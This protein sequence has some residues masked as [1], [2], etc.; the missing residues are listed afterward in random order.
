V[1]PENEDGF[2]LARPEDDARFRI[3]RNGDNLMTQFQCDLCQFRNIMMR[4]P[5]VERVESDEWLQVCIRR[6]ILDSLWSREPSTVRGNLTECRRAVK[7]GE[8]FGF[9]N[10]YSSMGP[11]PIEDSWG[12]KE[13]CILLHRSLDTGKNDITIQFGTMRKLRSAFSNAFHASKY[14]TGLVTMAQDARKT[15]VTDSPTYG[16]WF[17]RFMLG[18]HKRMGEKVKQ[19]MGVSIGVMHCL[20]DIFEKDF[21]EAATDKDKLFVCLAAL[22]CIASFCGG[23]RGEEVPMADLGEF[24]KHAEKGEDPRLPHIV[25]PLIGRFK[26]ER[27]EKHHLLPLAAV[28]NSGLEPRKWSLR[29]IDCYSKLH[30]FN[31]PI[32]RNKRGKQGRISDWEGPILDKIKEVQDG[33]PKLIDPTVDVHDEYGLSRSFRRGSNTH[34]RNQNLRNV[35]DIVEDNNRWRKFDRAKGRMPGMGMSDYY[36]EIRQAMPRLILYSKHQ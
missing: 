7:I 22:Y 3:G 16:I 17:Q 27:G 23:L 8:M 14:S 15:V 1:S 25:L 33:N 24:I 34:L 11:F 35:Q 19:D 20:M 6:A 4:D 26:G 5:D 18:C 9:K 10:N 30:V 36:T 13:A 12:L 2:Q 21:V 29:V 28:T 31:G 32:W